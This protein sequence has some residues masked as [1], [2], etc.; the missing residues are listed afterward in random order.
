MK[1]LLELRQE[2][3]T[4]KTQM[5][6]LLDKADGEK[7]SLNDEEGKQFDELRARADALDVEISR[8][9]AVSDEERHLPGAK[10]EGKG[11][12]NA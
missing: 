1:K 12:T 11:V 2:K 5:R 10:V 7:R 4:L 8:L 6:A 9:E 3:T